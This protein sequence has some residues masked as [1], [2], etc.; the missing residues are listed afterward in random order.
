VG[1][2]DAIKAVDYPFVEVHVTNIQARE[3]WRHHSMISAA[4]VGTIA[5]LG[6]R[7]YGL[8]L[9]YLVAHTREKS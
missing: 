5:G 1:L 6:W 9:R 7:G 2:H 3:E 8:A 4:A